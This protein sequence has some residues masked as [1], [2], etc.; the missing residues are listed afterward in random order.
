MRNS[1]RVRELSDVLLHLQESGDVEVAEKVRRVRD[2]LRRETSLAAEELVTT[3]QAA[4]MLGVA[5]VN[6][7]KRW[8]RDGALEGFRRGGRMLVSRD[9]VERLIGSSTVAEERAFEE[10]LEAAIA[11][12]SDEDLEHED[13]SESATWE[14]QKPWGGSLQR[15]RKRRPRAMIDACV[16]SHRR[17]WLLPL[18]NFA[19]AGLVELSWSPVIIADLLALGVPSHMLPGQLPS[20]RT[21]VVLA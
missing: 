16:F 17:E 6:T 13:P 18:L 19:R 9:S 20:G 10:R 14:G 7:V 21:V 15:S 8:I 3:G 4:T 5:S 2:D 12:F 1:E 11:P